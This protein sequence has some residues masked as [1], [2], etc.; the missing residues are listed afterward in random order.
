MQKPPSEK[1]RLSPVL[2]LAVGIL[3]VSSGSILARLAQEENVP[4]LVIAAYRTAVAALILLPIMLIRHRGEVRRLAPA[5]WRLALLSGLLLAVHFATWISSLAYTSVASSTV[6]VSTS[7]LWVA[8]AAPFLLGEPFT[9][10]LKIGMGLALAGTIVISL[11]DVWVVGENGRLL[12]NA[13]AVAGGQRPL[14]GNA[15]AL[16][17]AVA[18]AGYLLIGRKLRVRLSL[19]SYV[20]LV[21][22]TAAL[23]L[24]AAVYLTGSSMFGYSSQAYLTFLLMALGPQLLGHSS[25]NYALAFLPAA[26]VGAVS[27]AEP[28][29]ASIL[30]LLFFGEVPGPLVLLGSAFVFAGLLVA[31]RRR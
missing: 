29:G 31:G 16:T 12:I 27:F 17:G 10:P 30:A 23:S 24:I 14:L 1:P 19:V 3:A 21:Y 18:A 6:L 22:G 15:L 4:S 26:M 25:F 20:T 13:G 8:L 2:V 7:P 5:D 9:R 11:G 28:I